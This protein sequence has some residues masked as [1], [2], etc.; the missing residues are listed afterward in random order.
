[1]ELKKYAINGIEYELVCDSRNTRSG[2]A[3]DCTLF[4]NG[5]KQM[6]GTCYYYNRTWEAY[7]Y[8]TVMKCTVD[9]LISELK[10]DLLKAWKQA[11]GIKRMTKERRNEFEYGIENALPIKNL[12]ELYRQL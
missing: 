12:R 11:N 6:T 2:F 10:D 1:M 3:H 9:K 5:M 8:Q 4:K 7:R